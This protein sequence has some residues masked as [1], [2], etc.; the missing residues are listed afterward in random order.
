MAG[1]PIL[2]RVMDLMKLLSTAWVRQEL[3]AY[4]LERIFKPV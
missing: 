2:E 3:L 1:M 4:L